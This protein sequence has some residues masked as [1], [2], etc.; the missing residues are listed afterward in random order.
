MDARASVLIHR[1][2]MLSMTMVQHVIDLELS[3]YIDHGSLHTWQKRKNLREARHKI[4][5]NI[6]FA[7]QDDIIK[8]HH[9]NFPKG[10]V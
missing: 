6:Y 10:D 9:H 5:M 7:K 3:P 1:P 4:F 2:E 8:W